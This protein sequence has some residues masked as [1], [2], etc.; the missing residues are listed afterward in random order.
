MNY[1][2]IDICNMDN[3]DGLRVC[4][5]VAGCGHRCKGCFNPQTWDV[6]SGDLF[7]LPQIE[8][9][10]YAL[11][12][13]WCKGLTLTGG[14]P[15]FPQN[16]EQI[17]NLCESLKAEFPT[18]TIWLYTGFTYDELIKN[19]DININLIFKNID[20][21]VDGSYIKELNSPDKHWVGS[22]NQR[23][24]DVKETLKQGKVTLWQS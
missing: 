15:L 8:L 10:K 4:L 12:Q 22:S 24:I 23:L 20:V 17:S 3:G 1:H 5:W 6:H 11:S 16:R 19:N 18:K 13:D 7:E 9:I 14:D 2:K 21:L